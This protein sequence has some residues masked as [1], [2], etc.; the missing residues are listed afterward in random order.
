MEFKTVFDLDNKQIVQDG[1]M[2]TYTGKLVN[3]FAF[4]ADSLCIEDIAHGLSNTCR[5]NGATKTYF[6]VAEHCCMMHDMVADE[7][8][9]TALFHDCEE[10]YWGDIIKPLKKLLPENIR[11]KMEETRH[12]IFRAFGVP[13]ITET[14]EEV[15]FELLQWDLE[16]TI[17]YDLHGGLSPIEAKRG[18][19]QRYYQLKTRK[20]IR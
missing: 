16:N 20:I 10:A 1:C 14:I 3:L 6:S 18:F 4:S 13:E 8:K 15:D 5:W 2:I 11:H 17:K 7:F 12:I 19:L 9:A